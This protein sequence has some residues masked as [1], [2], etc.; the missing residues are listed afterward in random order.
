MTNCSSFVNMNGGD[1]MK[2]ERIEKKGKNTFTKRVLS[3]LL[4]TVVATGIF[5]GTGVTLDMFLTKAAGEPVKT[6]YDILCAVPDPE[7]RNYVFAEDDISNS[8]RDYAAEKTTATAN[9]F[10]R[11]P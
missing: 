11:Q 2:K 9:Y 8:S 5:A 10:A 4:A 7:L 1:I 3:M 6:L